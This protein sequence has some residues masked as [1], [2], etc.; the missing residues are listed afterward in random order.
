[1]KEKDKVTD[2]NMTVDSSG[3]SAAERA[4]EKA[5][6]IRKFLGKHAITVDDIKYILREDKKTCI[7]TKAG[8][9]TS[10]YTPMKEFI[11]FLPDSEFIHIDK[12]ILLARTQ[13]LSIQGENYYT[14]DGREFQGRKNHSRQHRENKARLRYAQDFIYDG[15][16]SMSNLQLRM[17]LLDDMPIAFCII[18][19]L[20]DAEHHGIDFVFRYCNKAM[21]KLE[22]KTIDELLNSSF[23]DIFSNADPKWLIAYAQTA[24][25]GGTQIIYD[26]SPEIGK[27][28]KITC[29]RP[30]QGFCG[31]LLEEVP[32]I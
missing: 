27:Q 30:E 29:F 31:C 26:Y 21:E 20:F 2:T 8:K 28:L 32:R 7:Y 12:G 6:K 15:Q 17:S 19:M 23:Y 24:L 5:E 11:D 4:A 22:G 14:I 13:I 1:M 9:I 10:T 16:G 3:S 18:E 25:Y